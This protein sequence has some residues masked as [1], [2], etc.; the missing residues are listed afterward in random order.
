[1]PTYQE[2]K[3]LAETRLLEVKALYDKG[4]YDGACYLAGYVIEFALKARIT[5]LLDMTHY[6]E[7]GE[8]SKSFKTHNYDILI[9]LSGL[10]KKFDEATKLNK[11]LFTNWS[12]VTKWSEEF[13]YHPVGTNPKEYVRQIINALEDPNDGVFTWI[14]NV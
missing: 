11:N 7:T 3:E 6:P 8:I 4:L 5:K 10:E 13:R 1:M 14:K 9:K 2:L 12:L